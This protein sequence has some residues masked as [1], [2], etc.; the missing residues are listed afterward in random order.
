[1]DTRTLALL[2]SPL[3]LLALPACEHA[4]QPHV[5]GSGDILQSVAATGSDSYVAAVL[6]D[7][8]LR[9]LDRAFLVVDDHGGVFGS[10]MH[11]SGTDRAAKWVAGA[12]GSM[13]GPVLLGTLPPPFDLAD[14]YVRS[15]SKNGSVVLG[16]AQNDRTYPTAGWVWENGTMTML[17]PVPSEGRVYPLAINGAGVIVGQIGMTVDEVHMDWGAVWLPPYDAEPI[18]LPRLEGYSLNSARGITN[19][20]VITGWVRGPG[21]VDALVQWEIDGAG[22]VLR[23]PDELQG[24]DQILMSA[25]NQDLDVVGSFHGGDH[26]EPYLFRSD[27][28]QRID[29]GLL[30]GHTAAAARGVNERSSDGSVQA[31]GSSYTTSV[32]HGRAVLWGVEANGTATGPVDLGLPP[33]W[34]VSN[35]PPRSLKFMSAG[36]FTINSDRWIV[37]WSQ[38]EDGALFSTLWQPGQDDGDDGDDGACDPHPRFPERCK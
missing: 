38:R 8:M 13:S 34:V 32:F 29:L 3:L 12:S 6:P 26:F 23:G 36:A 31:V 27:A 21:M 5:P 17:L 9:S 35:R 16:Y 33:A 19:D 7:G 10:V 4:T 20:G 24:I 28:G 2:V 18:L 22:N 1:M 14:Q 11:G 25:A 30:A 15:T 37:G